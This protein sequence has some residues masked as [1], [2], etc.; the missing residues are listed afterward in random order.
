MDIKEFER[1]KDKVERAKRELAKAEGALEE[2]MG[3]L[4]STYGCTTIE[5]AEKIY[6]ELEEKTIKL[7]KVYEKKLKQ[8]NDKW[9]V[10]H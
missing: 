6:E 5:E 9:D 1:L 4:K 3:Q 8:F 10:L 7:E 2:V